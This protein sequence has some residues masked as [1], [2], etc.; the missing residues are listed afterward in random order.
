MLYYPSPGDTPLGGLERMQVYYCERIDSNRFY[1]N[2]SQRLNYRLNLSA[3]RSFDYG[4]HSL[5][6]V[7]N[8]YREYKSYGDHYMYWY[9]YAW[10]WGGDYSGYDIRS[11]NSTFGLGGQAW[12]LTACFS[13]NRSGYGSSQEFYYNYAWRFAFST[14]WRT[15][16]YHRQ[17]FH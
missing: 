1:L 6:L 5:G 15:Y 3:G 12:D 8:I 16:G 14:S 9:T 7:Y 11:I 10:N 4:S 13:T 17:D 2:H